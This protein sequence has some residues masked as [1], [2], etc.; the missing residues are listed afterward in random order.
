[1]WDDEIIDELHRIREEHAKAFNY[2]VKAICADWRKR[3]A[4][5]GRKF[6]TLT[7]AN[8]PATMTQ[9]SERN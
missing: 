8:P 3:Q 2:D 4:Q 6:I 9:R 1:M 5:S 7:P